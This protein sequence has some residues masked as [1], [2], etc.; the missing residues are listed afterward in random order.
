MSPNDAPVTPPMTGPDHR[1]SSLSPATPAESASRS[2][3]GLR[4]LP[5]FILSLAVTALVAIAVAGKPDAR[6]FAVI[7][8]A[9]IAAIAVLRLF[10]NGRLLALTMINLIAVYVA[11][12]AFFIDE[13]FG[14]IAPDVVG[15]GFLL[16]PVAFLAG[17]WFWR[18]EVAMVLEAPHLRDTEALF[19]A[20][21]WL[22][23]VFSVG[24]VALALSF[25]AEQVVNNEIAYLGAM[26][27]IGLIV[28][29]L[30]R[31]I[32]IFLLDAGLLFEEFF[33]RM[34]RLAIPA[35]AFLTCYAMLVII[36]ASLFMLMAQYA[37]QPHFR[38]VGEARA[39]TF[40]EAVHFSITTLSTVGYGDIV[41]AS[42][43]ARVVASAE[44]I[45]GLL[46]LMF[47]VSELQEYAREHR[48][49]RDARALSA[50]PPGGGRGSL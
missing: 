1:R 17:C 24:G 46:L 8:T 32:A 49:Q 14:G 9:C 23:P 6:F 15:L 44:V 47:G 19:E 48:R 22:L 7:G 18:K 41:P 37:G 43:V 31:N 36:F 34:S 35:F 50:D 10:P 16:P 38:V 45:C 11:V 3:A 40:S 29:V 30:A 39:I 28:F 27:L 4:S 5:A 2:P 25:Y 12:F 13:L 33:R 42:N 26:A 21:K 20:L